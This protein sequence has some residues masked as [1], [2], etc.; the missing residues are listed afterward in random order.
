MQLGCAVPTS[1]VL[2]VLV[3]VKVLPFLSVSRA[4]AGQHR[5]PGLCTRRRT[6]LRVPGIADSPGILDCCLPQRLCV[7]FSSAF[8]SASLFTTDMY[9]VD[10]PPLGS[11]QAEGLRLLATAALVFRANAR[12]L[13]ERTLVN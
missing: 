6:V 4:C 9:V 13:A 1:F 5:E 2:K 10:T 8:S 11:Q 12:W 7:S 3:S